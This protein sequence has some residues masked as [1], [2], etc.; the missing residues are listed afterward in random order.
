MTVTNSNTGT[1]EN[2]SANCMVFVSKPSRLR[3][4]SGRKGSPSITGAESRICF[5]LTTFR[6]L[7]LLSDLCCSCEPQHVGIT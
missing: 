5:C 3:A 7:L 4:D 6:V 2:D 1:H